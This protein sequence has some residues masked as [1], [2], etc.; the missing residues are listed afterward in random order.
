MAHP[1]VE[2]LK[3]FGLRYGDKVAVGLTSGLFVL[4]LGAALAKKSIELKPEEVKKAAEQADSNLNRHQAREDIIK[5]LENGGIKPTEFAKEAEEAAKTVL[6]ADNYKTQ[7]ELVIPEPGAGL[8]RD[9]PTL[10]APTELYAY[11]GR[12]G[13]LVY[14]LDENGNRKPETEK[15]EAPKQERRVRRRR[16]A[17][18]G[19]MASMMGSMGRRRA[20]RAARKSQAEIER[21]QKADTEQKKKEFAAKLAGR[22]ETPD[23]TDEAA[24]K[25]ATN[26]QQYKEITKGLRWVAITGVLDHARL[27]ANYRQALKNPALANPHY[28]RLDLERQVRQ[29]DGSWSDWEKVD[30]EENLKILD[31]LPEED[32]ELTPDAVRPDNLNDPLPFLKAGLWEKVHIASLVPTEKKKVA[33][34]APMAGG[35]GDYGMMM[36]GGMSGS[37][38]GGMQ[39]MMARGMGNMQNYG[40]MMNRGMGSMGSGSMMAR[41]GGR[42]GLDEGGGGPLGGSVDPGNYWKSNEKRIMIRAL[43]FTAQPD[44]DYRYRLRIVVFNPNHNHDDV[45]AGVDTKSPELPGPWSDPTDEITMPADVSAYATDSLPAGPKSDIKVWFQ[46]VR[47][48][49]GDGVT[50]P[51]KFTAGPGEVIGEVSS[52][53]IPTSEGTGK[54]SKAVDFNTHQIVLD[55]MGGPQG[56]PTGFPGGALDRPGLALLLRPDGSVLARSEPD[57]LNN[58]IR[59]DIERNYAREIKDSNKERKNSMG[60][61][62]GGMMQMMMGGYGGSMGGG[63]YPGMGGAGRR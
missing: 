1:I 10:I 49:P 25:E 50:I 57:D 18:T 56:L 28:A 31:N 44:N 61:G 36:K 34:P 12:G 9:T 46:V 3:D 6:L 41:M 17:A 55:T 7:R 22:D 62:Y 58:E 47:F 27:V 60:A 33:A 63:G 40:Q 37:G 5:D 14:D 38:G 20:P 48:D 13:A 53:D 42:M 4:C 15:K 2:K 59:K 24:K 23:T 11:P 52:A 19:G 32:E 30:A 16:R 21:E 8:I 29:K 51:R 45:A 39:A 43:D 54:K 26:Q 35:M